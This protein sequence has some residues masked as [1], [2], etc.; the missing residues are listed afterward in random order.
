MSSSGLCE[1]LN[2]YENPDVVVHACN[3]RTGQA[4]SKPQGSSSLCLLGSGLQTH[5][6]LLSLS[7]TLRA[8]PPPQPS[9]AFHNVINLIVGPPL[10]NL[11]QVHS[12]PNDLVIFNKI[13]I[14]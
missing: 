10:T 6:T 13:L 11:A 7:S 4:D 14:I 3:P 9:S 5:S 1:F 12:P 2:P 8:E